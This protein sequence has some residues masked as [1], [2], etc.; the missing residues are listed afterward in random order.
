MIECIQNR[1]L[2]FKI[3]INKTA[4]RLFNKEYKDCDY[5]QRKKVRKE[6]KGL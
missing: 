3:A 1:D 6:L 5:F 4:N 2:M